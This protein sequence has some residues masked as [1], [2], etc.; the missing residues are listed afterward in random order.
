MNRNMLMV[1]ILIVLVL[2]A[3]VQAVQLTN[4]KSDIKNLGAGTLVKKTSSSPSTSSASGG[5]GVPTNLQ[6]LPGMVGGC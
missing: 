2:V 6:N 1:G 5:A 4:I 3:T